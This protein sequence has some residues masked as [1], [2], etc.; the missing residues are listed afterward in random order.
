MDNSQ[1][2]PDC[3]ATVRAKERDHA[4]EAFYE[5]WVSENGPPE[6]PKKFAAAAF[7]AAWERMRV[8][9]EEKLDVIT[10]ALSLDESAEWRA[11]AEQDP[12][13]A[14]LEM[15]FD[16]IAL[17][18]IKNWIECGGPRFESGGE[19]RNVTAYQTLPKDGAS[20][21]VLLVAKVGDATYAKADS[22]REL[23]EKL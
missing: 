17:K 3:I 14:I 1:V 23:A 20:Q 15:K 12:S 11:Q 9:M 19:P 16:A 2:K 4:F 18:K 10:A 13:A 5:R 21:G 7:E 6:A 8:N 22:L